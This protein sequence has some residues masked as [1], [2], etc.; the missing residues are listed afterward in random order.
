MVSS[1]WKIPP[2]NPS[3]VEFGQTTRRHL[4]EDRTFLQSPWFDQRNDMWWWVQTIHLK[5]QTLLKSVFYSRNHTKAVNN[6]QNT[7]ALKKIVHL[8]TLCFKLYRNSSLCIFSILLLLIFLLGPNVLFSYILQWHSLSTVLTVTSFL[9]MHEN[10]R[11]HCFHG[12]T[13]SVAN[14]QL[15]RL[16][17]LVPSI[18][19]NDTA[20]IPSHQ[21]LTTSLSPRF[22]ATVNPLGS[23]HRNRCMAWTSTR[24]PGGHHQQ[25]RSSRYKGGVLPSFCCRLL[26]VW[27][28][29]PH[30]GC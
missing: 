25:F 22:A 10:K 27:L 14:L 26:F 21:T 1:I 6:M 11:W 15:Q 29:K 20:N 9:L 24:P 13:G 23:H 4:A 28:G 18:W 30:S 5:P 19:E 3:V 12:R 7:F 8:A 2:Y 17:G 16:I